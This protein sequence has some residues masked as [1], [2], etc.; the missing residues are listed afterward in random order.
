M[1]KQSMQ[2]F[3]CMLHNFKQLYLAKIKQAHY[4]IYTIKESLSCSILVHAFPL[5]LKQVEP[6]YHFLLIC[7]MFPELYISKI[8]LHLAN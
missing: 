1:T 7:P 6:E 4:I 5:N 3:M 8:L 2:L